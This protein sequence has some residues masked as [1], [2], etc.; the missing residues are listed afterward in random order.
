MALQAPTIPIVA[1]TTRLFRNLPR[2]ILANLLFAIPFAA[3]TALTWGCTALFGVSDDYR[4][5]VML[6]TLIPLFPFYAGIASVTVKMV[7]GEEKPKVCSRFFSAVKDNF[8]RFLVH[9]V[10]LYFAVFFSYFSIS[11]YIRLVG[12]NTMFILPLIISILVSLVF[13]FA[14][15]YIPAMTVMFDIPMRYIYKNAFLMSF[16]E[17][18]NNFI[19]LFGLFFL[20][21]ICSTFLI[22]CTGSAV[23]VIIV[24]AVLA[25]V[26]VPSVAAFIIHS[27]VYKRMYEML[28]DSAN[29]TDRSRKI[30]EK[31]D[32]KRGKAKPVSDEEKRQLRESIKNLEI[33]ES[34]PDDEYIYF[35]GKMVKQSVIKKMKQEAL[36]SEES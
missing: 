2:L 1:V 28:S 13:L 29:R 34:I 35:N 5:F 21:I 19:G 23:A 18:K 8:G 27:A 3:F 36:E 16:G 12:Q 17:L 15:F 11:M 24:T 20:S 22:A 7:E 9:G 33:D 4:V 31:I 14:F 25:G 26:L 32:Q 30:D 10:V 6:L